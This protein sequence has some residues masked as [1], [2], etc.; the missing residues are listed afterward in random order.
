[1]SEITIGYVDGLV[2]EFPALQPMLRE[3]VSDNFGEVLPHVFFG[4]LTRYAVGEFVKGTDVAEMQRLLDRLEETFTS[5]GEDEIATLIADSFVE[6]LPMS[7]EQGEGI[8]DLLGPG[9]R[10]E[11]ERIGW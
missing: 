9:L 7:G 11:F 1:M 3:H 8:K 5:T 10:S 2:E 4:E 6:N